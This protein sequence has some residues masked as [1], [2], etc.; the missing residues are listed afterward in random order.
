MLSHHKGGS[1]ASWVPFTVIISTSSIRIAKPAVRFV[2]PLWGPPV[3]QSWSTK[4]IREHFKT[5]KPCCADLF[6]QN[7][8]ITDFRATKRLTSTPHLADNVKEALTNF[9]FQLQP[10][11]PE[12][13]P[14]ENHQD[15]EQPSPREYLSSANN[16][17]NQS[18]R[19]AYANLPSFRNHQLNKENFH[20]LYLRVYLVTVVTESR[21]C[22][23]AKA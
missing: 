12:F 14:S 4:L 17:P 2:T 3:S 19:S 16:R 8:L 22:G 7:N 15:L 5:E 18:S 21:L 20:P 10:A 23:E 1:R 11:T 13:V 9:W 6:L